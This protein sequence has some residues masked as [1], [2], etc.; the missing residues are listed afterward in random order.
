M[1]KT[2]SIT[3]TLLGLLFGVSSAHAASP[4]PTPSPAPTPTPDPSPTPTANPDPTT[5]GTPVTSTPTADPTPTWQWVAPTGNP[6]W[7]DF[8]WYQPDNQTATQDKVRLVCAQALVVPDPPFDSLD[9]STEVLSYTQ[10]NP[11]ASGLWYAFVSA[12]F[13][14]LDAPDEI[15]PFTESVIGGVVIEP[16]NPGGGAG[17]DETGTPG[18]NV[19]TAGTGGSSGVNIIRAAAV[20]GGNFD[21]TSKLPDAGSGIALLVV[22]TGTLSV[23][24]LAGRRLKHT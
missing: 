19:G 2:L 18:T 22:T 12:F 6:S 17:P 4:S 7:Y 14:R 10:Q 9:C 1:K 23:A 21:T 20:G 16:F 13:P 8:T 15:A 3:V 11:L 24:Y 5:P